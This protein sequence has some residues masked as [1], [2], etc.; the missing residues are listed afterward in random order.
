M[1]SYYDAPREVGKKLS[2]AERGCQL[3][4]Q[5][6][7]SP[8]CPQQNKKP[9]QKGPRQSK[10]P[11]PSKSKEPPDFHKL[12]QTWQSRFQKGKAVCKKTCTRPQPFNFSQKGERSRA[13][14]VTD[15]GI[16]ET[17]PNGQRPGNPQANLRNREPLTN[18]IQ[19]TQSCVGK[20]TSELEFKAD[21]AALA[22]ILSNVG[23][24]TITGGK[25]SLAQRVPMRVSSIAQTHKTNKNVMVRNSMYTMPCERHVPAGLDRM[26]CFS[27]MTIKA[28]DQKPLF[29][30]PVFRVPVTGTSVKESANSKKDELH[31]QENPLL[32]QMN[33]APCVPAAK[34]CTPQKP[35]FCSVWAKDEASCI[36]RS[37][38]CEKSPTETEG[39]VAKQDSAKK[40]D[41]ASEDFV[42]DSQALTS[43]LSNTGMSFANC[44]KLSLA[45]RVPMH[46]KMSF[47]KG[48]TVMSRGS[49][50]HSATPKPIH[51]PTYNATLPIKDFT[52]SPCRVP[53]NQMSSNSSSGGSARRV[54]QT[55][56]SAVKFS[57]QYP[58]TAKQPVFPKTP[59]ALAVEKANKRHV[60]ECTEFQS[61]TKSTVKWE[62]ELSPCLNS[63]VQC[64]NEPDIE[65]IAVRLFLDSECQGN[66]SK[67][68]ESKATESAPPKPE[69][70][71]DENR[72]NEAPGQDTEIPS[73]S[74]S[75]PSVSDSCC[76]TAPAVPLSFLSHPA[77]KALQSCTLG[78]C[79]LPDITR[80]RLQAAVSAKQRFWEARLD[81][82]CA[83]Y[84]SRGDARTCRNCRDPVSSHLERQEDMHFTPIFQGEPLGDLSNTNSST[85]LYSPE[86]KILGTSNSA[87]Q[88]DSH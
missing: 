77:V 32:Q 52:F 2:V 65:Q 38:L 41:A 48:D 13:Q 42:A 61:S 36:I 45:Q 17:S 75:Q 74:P 4:G 7:Y 78:S 56:A 27:K 20:G 34:E 39:S 37:D 23:V 51:G 26:S 22:S 68:K 66:S 62:D 10:L 16:P 59:R 12:H 70:A 72:I 64:E 35:K 18:V 84:T 71:R 31:P 24:P 21:P 25:V 11:V 73:C 86:S 57:Q 29:K 14:T 49:L 63:E 3:E 81:E 5:E 69:A 85:H 19:N 80:L 28:D 8:A 1:Q 79:S 55:K 50:I 76:S 82:E 33:Q 58:P 53:N 15:S 47:L 46:G 87:A 60:A 6:N 30:H 44:G 40:P 43:I 67:K 54:L 83:F 9:L 88:L